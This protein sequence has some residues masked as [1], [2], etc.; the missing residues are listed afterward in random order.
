MNVRY[1]GV[2]QFD[3]PCH[4]RIV[5]WTQSSVHTSVDGATNLGNV[6]YCYL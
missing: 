6:L 1:C 4:E 5:N 2:L 3:P